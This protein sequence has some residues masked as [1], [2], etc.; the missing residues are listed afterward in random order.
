[1]GEVLIVLVFLMGLVC[2]FA[3]YHWWKHE[4]AARKL[5]ERVAQLQSV[6]AQLANEQQRAHFLIAE[7]NRLTARLAPLDSVEAEAARTAA[8]TRDLYARVEELK[9]ELAWLEERIL[10]HEIDLSHDYDLDEA[11]SFTDAL[12]AERDRQKD[13]VKGGGAA[14]CTT[15]WSVGGSA[16]EGQRMVDRTLRLMLR[17]FNGEC[18][19]IMAKAKAANESQLGQRIVSAAKAVNKLGEKQSC[20]LTTSYVEFKLRELRLL[21]AY[22]L[23]LD[24][25]KEEQRRIREMMREEAK[26]AREV[27]KAQREAEAEERRYEQALERARREFQAADS[28]QQS[29]LQQQIAELEA[30][31]TEAHARSERAISQAQLTKRGHVYVISNLGSFGEHVFKIGMTRRLEPQDRVNELGDASVPF[32][33]DVHAMIFSEDAPALENALHAALN[34]H[35]VNKVNLRKEYFRVPLET[36]RRVVEQHHGAI[37]F[38]LAAEATEYRRT[39]EMV[40]AE[41]GVAA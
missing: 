22:Q 8:Q 4:R 3:L 40:R 6:E 21:C 37:Q 7:V 38:T 31:L 14:M 30:Q 34:A 29:I 16:K 18:D 1:M 11:G 25:Q 19:A 9:K 39:L 23:F 10:F 32:P 20:Q 35:R 5:G 24:E 2:P 27:E 12:R 26:V 41:E 33:F 28:A 15:T 36:I 13:L 17:A